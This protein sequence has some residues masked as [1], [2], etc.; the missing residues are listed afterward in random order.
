ML[1]AIRAA[2]QKRYVTISD[3]Y[4]LSYFE[5]ATNTKKPLKGLV[6]PLAGFTVDEQAG[7]KLQFAINAPDGAEK[8]RSM[9]Q[10]AHHASTRCAR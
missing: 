3:K 7:D 2:T 4:C 10:G 5:N 1:C 9:Q 8:V 6:M